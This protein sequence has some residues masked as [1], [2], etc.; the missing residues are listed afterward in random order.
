MIGDYYKVMILHLALT[1]WKIGF[2]SVYVKIAGALGLGVVDW[3]LK[4]M[5][6]SFLIQ[7]SV[8]MYLFD[9]WAISRQP[10]S[11][12]CSCGDYSAYIRNPITHT[13]SRLETTTL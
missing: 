12:C 9:R 8:M 6:A 7:S 2:L 4:A 10:S 13:R 5:F 3:V 1:D 11:S